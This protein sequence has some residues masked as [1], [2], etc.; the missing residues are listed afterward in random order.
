MCVACV[1]PAAVVFLSVYRLRPVFVSSCVSAQVL[2]LET[3]ITKDVRN[4]HKLLYEHLMTIR[5]HPAFAASLLVLSFESNLAFESQ[6]LLHY[7]PEHNLQKWVSMSEGAGGAHGWLTT[8][9]REEAMA[10]A[11]REAMRIGRISFSKFFFSHSADSPEA[12]KKRLEEEILNFSVV[13]EAP[14]NAFGRVRKTYTG[15]LAGLQDDTVIALQLALIA[16]KVFF[17]SPKYQSF[18]T[19]SIRREGQCLV[20]GQPP[21][22]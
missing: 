19:Q 3:L 18:S 6:H 12:A 8:A 11:L 10:L 14:K 7:L 2:G 1:W 22:R 13:T 17:E 21:H 16:S 15:K 5:R 4:T 9:A 20:G